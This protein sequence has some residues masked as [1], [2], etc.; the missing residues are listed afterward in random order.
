MSSNLIRAFS[1]AR[2][3]VACTPGSLFRTFS[4]RVE[5]AVQ[6]IPSIGISIFLRLGGAKV[7]P[8]YVDIL[9]NRIIGVDMSAIFFVIC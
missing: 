7:I 5:Q 1:L 9:N 6:V 3:T 8:G 2:L 4:M